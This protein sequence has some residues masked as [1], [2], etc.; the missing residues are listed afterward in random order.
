MIIHE[1][2]IDMCAGGH[3]PTLR[4]NEGDTDFGILIHLYNSS[5]EFTIQS[6]TTAKL[7][8]KKPDHTGY[9]MPATLSGMD[10]IVAGTTQLTNAPGR[11]ELEVCLIR[12]G[13]KLFSQNFP[14]YV[15]AEA[16][17]GQTT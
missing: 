10:V 17:G 8:G 13:K 3:A 5:G 2:D 15:E 6:G 1:L 11:G 4:V 16:D 9:E 12:G 14:V 7:F